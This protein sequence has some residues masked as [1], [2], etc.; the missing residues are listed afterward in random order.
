MAIIRGTSRN[1]T[2]GPRDSADTLVGGGGSDSLW[3][4]KSDD[5]IRGGLGNDEIKCG[6]GDDLAGGAAGNDYL[7]GNIGSDTVY[8]ADGDDWLR[9]GQ[10]NDTLDGGNGVDTLQGDKAD[11]VLFGGEGDDFLYGGEGSDVIQGGHGDD[12]IALTEGAIAEM[13]MSYAGGSDPAE[14]QSD[15]NDEIFGWTQNSSLIFDTLTLNGNEVGFTQNGGELNDFMTQL[16]EMTW[17]LDLRAF[18]QTFVDADGHDGPESTITI[19][20]LEDF[21]LGS[22]DIQTPSDVPF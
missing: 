14:W 4:G 18:V 8:G 15:G 16:D 5:Q 6:K 10:E 20:T 12:T 22:F 19:H 3:G 11:D 9:G 13:H 17:E 2:I 1:D 21:T 7:H